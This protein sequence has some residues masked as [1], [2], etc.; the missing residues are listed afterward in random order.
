MKQVIGR[1]ADGSPSHILEDNGFMQVSRKYD[2]D[3]DGYIDSLVHAE[4]FLAVRLGDE[5]ASLVRQINNL[6]K[7]N[8]QL[9]V[10]RDRW[11]KAC[12]F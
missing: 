8:H 6:I 4:D 3:H 12:G 5:V 2:P 7:E 1:D 10:E 9:R 11:Q